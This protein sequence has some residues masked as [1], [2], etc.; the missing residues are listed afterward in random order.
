V[1]CGLWS[2]VCGRV[3][4][5]LIHFNMATFAHNGD[6]GCD[7]S[8]WNVHAS[9]AAGPTSDPKTFNPALLNVSQWIDSMH[10]VGA[11]HSVL[12]A[13]HGCGHLN[14]PTNTTLPD[15]S[16]CGSRAY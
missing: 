9:Y 7:A 2:V 4:Q 12:T 10:A 5:A 15:G 6:P 13:K 11:K 16:R 14:W 8:N 1:V 3:V